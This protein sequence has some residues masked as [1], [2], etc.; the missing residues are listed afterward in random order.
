MEGE[1]FTDMLV[2]LSNYMQLCEICCDITQV[3]NVN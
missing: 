3:Q 2:Y 1:G